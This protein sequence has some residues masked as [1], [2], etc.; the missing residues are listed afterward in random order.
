MN[1]R[2]TCH[3]FHEFSRVFE[4]YTVFALQNGKPAVKC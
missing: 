1:T 3:V 4:S 2:N